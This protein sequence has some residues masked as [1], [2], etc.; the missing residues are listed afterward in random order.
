MQPNYRCLYSITLVARAANQGVTESGVLLDPSDGQRNFS[1]SENVLSFL[2]KEAKR[3]DVRTGSIGTECTTTA[4]P[5]ASSIRS[6]VDQNQGSA[7][8]QRGG[9][10]ARGSISPSY[11]GVLDIRE[12]GSISLGLKALGAF[13]QYYRLFPTTTTHPTHQQSGRPIIW[14]YPHYLHFY[15]VLVPYFF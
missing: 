6:V 8:P 10:P 15:G 1:Q 9:G 7:W 14:S 5:L 2:R 4:S 3:V 13:A 11:A 12:S